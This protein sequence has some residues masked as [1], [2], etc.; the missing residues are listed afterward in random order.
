MSAC[1]ICHDSL[2]CEHHRTI[3][4]TKL[5][6]SRRSKSHS[7]SRAPRD[8]NFGTH[9]PNFG[10]LVR[11]LVLRKEQSD[12]PVIL[13]EGHHLLYHH[14]HPSCGAASSLCQQARHFLTEVKG[15]NIGRPFTGFQFSDRA[16]W[17]TEA[18]RTLQ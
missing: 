17:C 11:F 7:K 13:T 8:R 16:A 6:P 12:H 9:E 3:K 2:H 18:L 14:E 5:K 15:P 1:S 10:Q 4:T